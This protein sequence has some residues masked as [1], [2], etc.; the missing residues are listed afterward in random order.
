M[1][2][3]RVDQEN[4][5]MV[6]LEKGLTFHTKQF[7]YSFGTVLIYCIENKKKADISNAKF[8]FSSPNNSKKK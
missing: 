1:P 3:S 6:I 4:R 5:L 2:G 7:A 8:K